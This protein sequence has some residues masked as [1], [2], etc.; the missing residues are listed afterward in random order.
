MTIANEAIPTPKP[1]R[2]LKTVPP[3]P[4]TRITP[5]LVA[6]AKRAKELKAQISANDKELETLKGVFMD[7][8]VERGGPTLK[9][10]ELTDGRGRVVVV[11]NHG[12]P[13]TLDQPFLRANYPEIAEECTWI[14]PWD[15]PS[16]VVDG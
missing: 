12:S 8:F 11:L 2:K 9:V 7:I 5:A 4:N 14:H 13:N 16:F 15:S 1:E 10:R 3:V 6:M